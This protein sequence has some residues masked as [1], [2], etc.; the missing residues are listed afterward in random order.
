MRLAYKFMEARLLMIGACV[1]HVT[2]GNGD[3]AAQH[4]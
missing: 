2:G 1:A 4:C 3:W